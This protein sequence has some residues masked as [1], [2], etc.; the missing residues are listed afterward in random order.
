MFHISSFSIIGRLNWLDMPFHDLVDANE[1]VSDFLAGMD[2]QN[3]R[4]MFQQLVRATSQLHT[5]Q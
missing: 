5:P 2:P 1:I 3:E 4:K